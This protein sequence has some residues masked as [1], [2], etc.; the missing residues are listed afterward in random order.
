MRRNVCPVALTMPTPAPTDASSASPP[1]S[2]TMAS[3][4]SGRGR[5][6]TPGSG[7]SVTGET[8][9]LEFAAA[10]ITDFLQPELL[11]S[12]DYTAVNVNAKHESSK[13]LVKKKRKKRRKISDYAVKL[14]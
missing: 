2:K 11:L 6:T 9:S 14:D 8:C 5:H 13:S 10:F 7:M 1:R 3:Q 4:T 12:N